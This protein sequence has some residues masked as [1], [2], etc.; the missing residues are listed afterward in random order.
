[1][2][3]YRLP[4]ERYAELHGYCM[5]GVNEEIRE[6]L[7]RTDCGAL[8]DWIER[9][10]CEKD[11]R[12]ARMEARGIPCNGDTF[13]VYRAKFYYML[14]KILSEEGETGK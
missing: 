13:R 9:H 5:R 11:W 4:R 3:M 10:V 2:D 14:D 12:W 8:A 7:R 1:M 6:A